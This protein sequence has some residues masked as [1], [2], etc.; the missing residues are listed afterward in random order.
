M[1]LRA[2]AYRDEYSPTRSCIPKAMLTRGYGATRWVRTATSQVA[3][4]PYRPSPCLRA[5]R[6]L[7]RTIAYSHSL[8]R[9]GTPSP[10]KGNSENSENGSGKSEE[11]EEQ[12]QEEQDDE[13]HMATSLSLD[14]R[15]V[16][17]S[18]A[19]RVLGSTQCS[20]LVPRHRLKKRVGSYESLMQEIATPP[21]G[22]DSVKVKSNP[23]YP[24]RRANWY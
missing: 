17:Y 21:S 6:V 5:V 9:N 16:Q 20:A 8:L 19:S 22:M 10:A 18:V 11:G 24:R 7:M 14:E 1:V 12:E 13:E 2:P 3:R 4:P 15:G 23:N